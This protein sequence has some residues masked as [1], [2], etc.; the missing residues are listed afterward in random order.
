MSIERKSDRWISLTQSLLLHGLVVGA[1]AY[2]CFAYKRK[3]TP[4]QPTLAVEASV[5]EQKSAAPPAKAPEP[6]PPA[7]TPEPEPPPEDVGPPAPTQEEIQQREQKER[8]AQQKQEQ[9][10]READ[11]RVA[12]ERKQ[13]EEKAA[14]D[15]KAREEE[16]RKRKAAEAKAAEEKRVADAKRKAEEQRKAELAREQAERDAELRK[17]LEA[18]E[19]ANQLRSSGVQ[20]AW[21]A[22]IQAR[23]KRA[24]SRPPSARA[25][26]ECVVRITQTTG[27]EVTGVSVGDCNGDAAVRA[28]IE[29]AVYRASPL[30]PAPDPAIFD[31]NLTFN[32]KPTD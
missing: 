1:L 29:D 24:G 27:G 16:D 14:A 5:A 28:S 9:Q 15:A 8:E 3:P 10:K 13:A 32:F 21:L 23:V 4:P 20:N 19:R 11:E 17:T 6:P 2:G 7:P 25:G 18:E 22:A 12:L 30:P 26:I 31:R